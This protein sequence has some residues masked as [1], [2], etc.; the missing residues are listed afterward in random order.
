MEIGSLIGRLQLAALRRH[1]VCLCLRSRQRRTGTQACYDPPTEHD[2]R[3]ARSGTLRQPKVRFLFDVLIR[4][5]EKFDA[6]FE[7][8]DDN[9]SSFSDRFSQGR[10]IAAECALKI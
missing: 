2:A 8:A 4:T 9:S 3:L 5:E 10:R 1:R 7:H 6:W